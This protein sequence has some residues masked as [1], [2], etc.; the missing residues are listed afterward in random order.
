VSELVLYNYWRSSSSH[1]VRIALALKELAYTY[2]A[3]DLLR[4]EQ[5]SEA[6]AARSP[7]GLVPCLAIDGVYHVESVAIIELVDELFP[8]RPLYPRDPHQ[9][10]RVRTLVEIVNSGVQPLHNM[11]V[12]RRASPDHD[13]QKRWA[14][15]FIE[16]GLGALERALEANAREGVSGQ[17][18]YGDAP[19]AADAFLVPQVHAA[20]R[21]GVD[22]SPFP[23]VAASFEAAT[24]LDAVKQAA[25]ERQPDAP[26]GEKKSRA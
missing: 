16:R 8:S 10:A 11:Y 20:A 14:G 1:R 5:S 22:I 9:R 17:Y 23:R 2:V 3:V 18:A 12:L 19:T 21:F 13:E 4:G 26:K 24:R 7:T 15:H 25:P 6:H